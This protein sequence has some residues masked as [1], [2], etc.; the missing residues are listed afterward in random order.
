MTWLSAQ[1][2][3]KLAF[4]LLWVCAALVILPVVGI[5]GVMFYRGASGLSWGLLVAV[6]DGLLAP[7]VGTVLLV[8]LTAFIAYAS[9]SGCRR[10]SQRI[11]PWRDAG[12]LD[13]PGHR[14]PSRGTLG[15]LW[16]VWPGAFRDIV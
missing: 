1:K 15:C 10:L 12:T 7:I 13:S 14:K 3:E 11:L 6:P 16:P 5:I 9:G 4:A 8:A 2:T